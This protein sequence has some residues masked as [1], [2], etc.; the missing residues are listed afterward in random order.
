MSGMKVRV[1]AVSYLNTRP[2]V[3][4][5]AQGMGADRIELSFDVPSRLAER[6][7]SS[8]LEV[9]LLPTI[10][11]ARIP[12]LTIVPGLGITSFGAARS[13][14]LVS[15]HPLDAIRS[16]ALDPESRT[17]NALV[18]VLFAEAWGGTPAFAHGP[19]S[20]DEALDAHDA[21]VRIGD[22]ALFDPLPP[23]TRA[24]DLGEAWTA[25]TGLPFVWAVWAAIPAVVDRALYRVFHDSRREGGRMLDRIAEDYV[26]NGRRDPEVARS[27]LR[28]N[29]RYRL[30][31]QEVRAIRLFHEAAERI[32]LVAA[33]PDP[34]LAVFS[35]S[36]CRAATHWRL[37]AGREPSG[38]VRVS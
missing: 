22:K 15:K 35:D 28:H 13:V 6:L 33:A 2:L 10:E 8:E 18:Q 32:G 16:V 23:G 4:G 7:A 38:P 24:Y 25:R 1:G 20:I 19:G 14:L 12:G 36:A 30:G 29:M 34:V 37:S 3:L 9:A 27:Y 17:S 5:M 11:L 31:A 26:W 21:V